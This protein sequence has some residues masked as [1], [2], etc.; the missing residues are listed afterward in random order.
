[1]AEA[2]MAATFNREGFTVVNH[3]T[4][5][6][7]GDG[8]LQEGV[9]SEAS[10]LAG[11]LGLG[12]LIVLYDDNL[13][14]IDGS[15][16]LSFTE[17]VAARYTSYNWH[18]QSVADVNDLDALRDAIDTARAPFEEWATLFAAYSS[19]H[20]YLAEEFTRRMKGELPTGWK[21]RLPRYPA[22]NE[23]KAIGTRNHSEQVLN[24]LAGVLP[25]IMGGSA[26][27]TPSNLTS[28][29]CCGEFQRDSPDGRYVRFGVREHGMAAIC[30]GLYA[31]GGL[32]PFGATFL[33]FI[34]YALGSVRLTALSRL[35]VIYVMTH[36]S[37]GLGEDGP[38]HQPVEMLESLRAM[39]N[40]LVFRPADGNEVCGSYICA[41]ENPKSPSVIALSRQVA[42]A[43][44]GSSVEQVAMGAYTLCKHGSAAVP[45]LVLVATGT[46]VQLAVN[47]AKALAQVG[48]TV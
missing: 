12:K 20:P 18:V 4:Y 2:H 22:E 25:E 33:N 42:P 46:E 48:A 26:D 28:L 16:E 21:D 37:I 23:T 40:M 34:G 15:T 11:H 30:N 32:R 47:V 5:V 35:G 8:C 24:A 39:P 29:K 7:C 1:M 10:S 27:L 9:S 41:V 44:E 3:F 38:T 43:Q 45:S 17:D 31:Y 6:I 19:A 36:D 14:T 13:I